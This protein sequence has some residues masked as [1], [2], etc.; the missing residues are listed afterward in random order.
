MTHP[1]P[2]T[3]APLGVRPEPVG[4][5]LGDS[6]FQQ[7]SDPTRCDDVVIDG[8]PY[9]LLSNADRLPPFLMSV[10][11]NSDV[12]LFVGSNSAFTAGRGNPD[13]G[14]FPYQTADKILK[15]VD[16]SGALTVLLVSRSNSGEDD[17]ALWEPWRPSGGVYRIQRNLFKHVTG[18]SVIFEEINHD[19]RVSFRWSLQAGGDCG[20][21]RKCELVNLDPDVPLRVRCLDGWHQV[22][23]P[24]VTV[25]LFQHYSYLA[26]AYMRHEQPPGGVLG[27]YTM[28]SGITDRAEPAEALRV[29]CAWSLGHESPQ[30]LVSDTQV[31][32]FRHGHPVSP[33]PEIRGRFGAYLVSTAFELAAGEVRKWLSGVDTRLDHADVVALSRDLDNPAGFAA[34]IDLALTADREGLERRIG[35]CDGLQKTADS[36]ASVHHFANTLF[37]CMRGGTLADDYRFTTQDFATFLKARNVAVHERSREWID[38]LPQTL[39]LPELPELVLARSDAQLTRLSRE[40]LP[41]TFSRRHGDPSRPWNRFSIRLVD[42]AGRAVLGYEGNWRDIF[43]NWEGLAQ[44]YP[45]AIGPMI[46]VFLNASTADGYNPYRVT[47][48][49]IDWEVMDPEDPWSH[50]GYWGDHQIIYLLRLLET[51]E[52]FFPGRI[53]SELGCRRFCYAQVP[54]RIRGLDDLLI[55]PQNSVDFDAA[56]HQ[57]LLEESSQIGGDAKMLRDENGEV[58][59][60]SLTEKLL[61]PV[62]AKLS[63][64]VPG[65]GIWLNTQR[66]EWND[67]N[68]ALAGWGLSMVTVCYLRRHLVFLDG[69]FEMAESGTFPVNGVVADLFFEIA[70]AVAVTPT[71]VSAENARTFLEAV[72]A[73]G[74]R[75]RNAVYAGELGVARDLDRSTVR[76]FLQGAVDLLDRT[77]NAN[78]TSDGMYHSYNVMQVTAGQ[79]VVRHLHPML[80]GQVAVLSSGVLRPESALDLLRALRQSSLYRA[81]QDSYLLYA[82]REISPYLMRNRLPDDALERAPLLRELLASDDRSL[83]CVDVLGDMHFQA[84]FT[85][86]GDLDASLVRLAR[87]PRWSDAVARDAPIV[88]ELWEE[89]FRHSSFT[90]RSGTMFGFEG[91]GSIYWHMV[92]KLLLAVQEICLSAFADSDEAAEDLAEAY[93]DVR[94]GLGF[95]KRPAVYGAFPTDPYSHTPRDRGA[96]QPGM[97]GQVKEELLTRR[98]ELGVEVRHG[99]LTL[100]PTILARAEFF[101]EA[102][103]CPITGRSLPPESLAFTVGGTPIHYTIGNKA[104]I[105]V[106]WEGGERELLEGHTLTPQASRSIFFRDREVAAIRVTIPAQ[107]LR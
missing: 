23:P 69:I 78:R 63:N 41:L 31:E 38:S 102:S 94:R 37:N 19:L 96:Q 60:V 52:Q 24:G 49:G 43:Q 3:D 28:N 99:V 80:E 34:T 36:A 33:E 61:V 40:Y 48:E 67:A 13:C 95:M 2:V 6:P 27:I 29:T 89:V 8:E 98:G 4:I 82:D 20:L 22:M 39:T 59:L 81:D 90:G 25:K 47:R 12:W 79:V 11:S 26:A 45:H 104:G 14:I 66:P 103:I 35:A 21:I 76:N 53:A 85:N 5:R 65:G 68:N 54:Y 55:D 100:A 84:D 9:V 64:F 58:V 7:A 97:T 74:E 71:A 107:T 86:V 56:L 32:A 70:D 83:V 51:C 106:E 72:G 101:K 1:E 88:R 93:A 17:W 92:A 50:I 87:E 77:I 105:V 91:L 30:V 57:R 42:E 16:S 75:H 46:S 18:A 10:V 15:S 44:S 62:L 73:A